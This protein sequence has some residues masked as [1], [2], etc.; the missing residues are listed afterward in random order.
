MNRLKKIGIFASLIF[1]VFLSA[2]CRQ[3]SQEQT[4]VIRVGF[5]HAEVENPWRMA[6]I[7]SFR[8]NIEAAGYEFVYTEP[9]ERTMQ[10]QIEN[11]NQMLEKGLDFLF[12]IPLDSQGYEQ[13]AEQA[14]EQGTQVISLGQPLGE[15]I[16]G[17]DYLSCIY[18]DYT[19]A[20]RLCGQALMENRKEGSYHILEIQSSNPAITEK[21]SDGFNQAISEEEDVVVVHTIVADGDRIATQKLLEK[22]IIE[23]HRKNTTIHAVFAHNDE[24]GLGALNALKL[25]GMDMKEI[26]IVSINGEQDVFKAI[27]A[28]EYLAAVTCSPMI[29]PIACNTIRLHLDGHNVSPY[30]LIPCLLVDSENAI[31]SYINAY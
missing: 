18:Y 15:L 21:I 12:I 17:T 13:I 25:A 19:L 29:G 7:N 1:L 11:I 10:W 2:G 31:E 30:T 23:L 6:Q 3:Q 22:T 16:S 5:S 14:K 28:D 4:Q 8:Q 20:G 9:L 26:D 24:D 27:I